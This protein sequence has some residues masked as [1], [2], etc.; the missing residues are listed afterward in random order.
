MRLNLGPFVWAERPAGVFGWR[1]PAGATQAIDFRG[2]QGNDVINGMGG[3]DTV[4]YANS[5]AGV[6]SSLTTVFVAGPVVTQANDALGD[7]YSS[8]ENMV[9][10]GFADTLIGESGNNVID[11]GVGDD[12]LEGMDGADQLIGG[13]GSD[14]ASYAHASGYVMAS[15][16]TGL[17]GFANQGH[18]SGDTYSS[19]ENLTGSDFGDTLIGDTGINILTGGTGDDVLEGM[20]GADQQ[21]PCRA[22]A[23][24]RNEQRNDREQATH[25]H[26]AISLR[27]I[28]EIAA[29]GTGGE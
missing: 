25:A 10:T 3:T 13:T 15:L 2:L 21:V 28:L 16:T 14:T 9:G 19:I 5:T 29:D 7:T 17:A 4:S 8:I 12:I 22:V 27:S 1:M 6:V 23:A 24:Q 20:G 11:G 26:A 18:A